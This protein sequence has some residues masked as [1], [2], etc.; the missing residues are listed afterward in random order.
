MQY[1]SGQ[2]FD[3]PRITEAGRRKGCTV[4]FDLAHAVGNVPLSLHD[5]NVDF[6]VW[7][8]YK[9]LNAGPGA[10]AGCFVHERHHRSDLPR[11]AGWWG[12]DPG[13]RFRMH[14]EAEFAPVPSADAWQLSNPPILA[15]AP[16]RVSLEIFDR[17][18]MDALREKSLRLTEYLLD[19]IASIDDP[20]VTVLTPSN[21]S[22]RG[23][24]SSIALARDGRALFE[25]LRESGVVCDYREP[26][27]I[28]VAPV[29]LYN[30]FH[31]VW[32]FGRALRDWV[33]VS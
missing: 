15:A 28:R 14:L 12:N 2:L 22:E 11:F 1:Y 13:T 8:S 18:G 32:R 31:D 4:G 30:S 16:L 29:P 9:Y 21:P 5:W 10:V 19:W 24:Q 23:C 33:A 27:V 26:G 17:V 3:L 20:R 6:A 25:R 7:C